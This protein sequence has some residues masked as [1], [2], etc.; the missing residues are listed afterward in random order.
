MRVVI[1]CFAS[2]AWAVAACGRPASA[3]QTAANQAQPA[4]AQ[5][6]TFIEHP[7]NV[8]PGLALQAAW[9]KLVNPY[10]SDAQRRSEGAK[11]F[12]S[13]N[14]MDC[15]GPDGSGAMAPSFQDNRWHFGG[16]AG[17]VFQSIYEGR[18][19]GMPAWGGRIVDVPI[20]RLVTYVRSRAN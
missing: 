7:Q 15:H 3:A 8:Q 17:E 6:P 10:E 2:L 9:A 14:C 4:A 5:A 16:S 12:V 11:L 19:D 1:A 20:R 18:P 13:Y